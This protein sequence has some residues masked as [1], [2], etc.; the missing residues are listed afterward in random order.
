MGC[1]KLGLIVPLVTSPT[2]FSTP[3]GRTGYPWRAMC[4]FADIL[5]PT[6]LRL[7]PRAFCSRSASAPMNPPLL[8]SLTI[9][10]NPASSGVCCSS[11]SLPYSRYPASRRSVS[12]APSPHGVAPA[13]TAASQIRRAP[14]GHGG[15]AE[16]VG[17][18]VEHVRLAERVDQLGSSRALHGHLRPAVALLLELDP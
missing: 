18:H 12:R 6:S 15:L 2:C 13:S 8:C 5:N 17:G 11:M 9:H 4:R 1:C 3:G 14:S 10:S 7:R 16:V